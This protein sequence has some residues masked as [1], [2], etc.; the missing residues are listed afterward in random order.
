VL[1]ISLIPT[2]LAYLRVRDNA[3]ERDQDR[4]D[5][6]ARAKHDAVERRLVRYMDEV[7][8]LGGF[9]S[10]SESLDPAEWHR[11]V[12]NI[13]AMERFPGFQM[14]GFMELVSTGQ[15]AAHQARWRAQAGPGY[16]ISPPGERGFYCPVV[17]LSQADAAARALVGADA[18]M[19]P[20]LVPALDAARDLGTVAV[21]AA[22]ALSLPGERPAGRVIL[23]Q[24]VFFAGRPAGTVEERRAALRGFVFGAVSVPRLVEGIFDSPDERDL[25]VELF[26]GRQAA[27]AALLFSAGPNGQ[28]E[29]QFTRENALRVGTR[30]W[31]LTLAST[32]SF[33]GGLYKRLPPL[34]LGLGI[35]VNLLLFGI[36]WSQARSRMEAERLAEDLRS[37]QERDRLLERATNDAIWDW[38]IEG[39]RLAWNEAVQAMFRY[40][41]GAVAPTLDWWMERLH[42]EDRRRVWNGREAAVQTGGEF[43][44]DEYRF[45]RGDGS[46]AYVIDRGYIIHDR[47]G[48]AVRMIRLDGG[49]QRP[50]RGGGGPPAVRA[51]ARAPHPAD[52]AGRHRVEP[53]LPGHLVEPGGGT[54]LR[55]RRAR[56][57]GPARRR[58]RAGRLR[59]EGAGHQPLH[60]PARRRAAFRGGPRARPA[61][62]AEPPQ[63]RA[64]RRRQGRH[65]QAAEHQ[66]L[67][68][69]QPH[70]GR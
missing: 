59:Q 53:Q 12:R 33:E 48:V 51:Q 47:Q 44:A 37:V 19:D 35:S 30:E 20:V 1:I 54:H 56:G 63:E 2:L 38:D 57:D 21:S 11:F 69:V 60:Q 7:V 66:C 50:A 23:V 52:A 15:R 10:A 34:V 4:F 40:S 32:P 43:W 28:R 39:N 58:T 67:R 26:D 25:R 27:P 61:H 42:S 65:Q 18:F 6:I 36:A 13:T 16:A 64:R 41:A 55:L 29:A 31:L 49:H 14:L 46:F 3:R 22:G 45:R 70:Q 24:P 8:S 5:Q 68:R 17:L 9:F 62:L